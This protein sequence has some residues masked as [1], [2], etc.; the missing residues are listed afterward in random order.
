MNHIRYSIVLV[1][2]NSLNNLYEYINRL[3]EHKHWTNIELI[4]ISNSVYQSNVQNELIDKYR[5]V[6]FFFIQENLGYAKAINIASQFTN[7]EYL[8]ISN[9]NCKFIH[10]DFSLIDKI[11]EAYPDVGII[12]PQIVNSQNIIQ[13][14]FREFMSFRKFFCRQIERFI[15]K[16][17]EKFEI[18]N[19][20]HYVDWVIG[21]CMIIKKSVFD[22]IQ[23][24]DDSYFLYVEDMDFCKN[25]STYHF[26]TIYYPE[27]QVCY[28][29][30]RRSVSGFNRF[31]FIHIKSYLLFLLK[32]S[33]WK[34][35]TKTKSTS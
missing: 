16:K 15:F 25:A 28:N 10:F 30:S 4:V 27:L 6:R 2:Y 26:K 5:D 11:C 29:S 31:T 20:T 19:K 7:G 14:S 24:F 34:K 21:A 18:P 3:Q 12:G 1:E 17:F 9:P 8:I 35:Y 23:G 13:D 22:T 33:F 32:Y